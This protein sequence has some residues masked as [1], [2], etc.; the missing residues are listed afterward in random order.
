MLHLSGVLFSFFFRFM[1]VITL[2]TDFGAR[3]WFV[4]T[5]K[6]VIAGLAPGA[7]VIDILH[8]V[9]PGN[10]RGG[11]FALAA[12]APFFPAG[13]IHV[14]VV[15]P[16]VGSARRAIALRT[17]DAIFVGPDN[18]VLSWAVREA[19]IEDIRE[20]FNAD[21][22]LQPL[23]RTFHGRDVFAPVAARLAAG[24]PFAD[25]GGTMKDFTRIPWPALAHSERQLIGEV[26]N[27]DHFG[28][29]ITNLPIDGFPADVVAG[30]AVQVRI[31]GVTAVLRSCYAAGGPGEALAVA[32]SS[33]LLEVAFNDGDF[34]RAHGVKEG[35]KVDAT[36]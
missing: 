13:T 23:S 6:G 11:A 3:D 10:V 30:S 2:T 7:Q 8:E 18:R 32:G 19:P 36:W 15:D 33:G 4:G 16:S 24:A 34:A 12:A 9:A 21:W 27:V 1:S 20:I 22:L 28:N 25:V 14:A 17:R 29:A 26:V 5:M 35:A 31:G